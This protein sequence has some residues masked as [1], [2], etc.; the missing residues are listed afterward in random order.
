MCK[1]V[2]NGMSSLKNYYDDYDDHPSWTLMHHRH[3]TSQNMKEIK[4]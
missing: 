1:I 2:H 3:K 4:S